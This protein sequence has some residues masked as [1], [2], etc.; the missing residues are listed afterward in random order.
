MTSL[1]TVGR[2]TCGFCYW[3][4][5]TLLTISSL[6]GYL[7]QIYLWAWTLLCCLILIL[8]WTCLSCCCLAGLELSGPSLSLLRLSCS[9]CILR[10][11]HFS[12]FLVFWFVSILAQ[13]DLSSM[14]TFFTILE[15]FLFLFS[16]S[17]SFSWVLRTIS[18]FLS[19]ICFTFL[20]VSAIIPFFSFD[21]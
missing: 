3:N 15:V 11:L 20:K 13:I 21:A 5:F 6:R 14:P 8:N 2:C 9:F 16:V 19:V 10:A 12:A 18:S 17:C 1:P 4:C 7:T